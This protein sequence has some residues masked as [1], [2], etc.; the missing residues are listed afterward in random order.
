MARYAFVVDNEV[1]II[2]DVSDE[3]QEV[4]AR[5][6]ACLMSQPLIVHTSE[7]TD[8]GIGWKWNGTTFEAPA[9]E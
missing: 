9:V 4:A 5:W 7:S 6:Y 3:D 8:I 1:G 2:L